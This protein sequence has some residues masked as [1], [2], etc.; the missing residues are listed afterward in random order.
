MILYP[1]QRPEDPQNSVYH[2]D[3][4]LETRVNIGA[5]EK[6]NYYQFSNAIEEHWELISKYCA[7]GHVVARTDTI[8]QLNFVRTNAF[9][10]VG[11]VDQ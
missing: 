3:A 4:N 8:V 9:L 10:M 5:A 11:S 6:T 7:I 2:A 1:I